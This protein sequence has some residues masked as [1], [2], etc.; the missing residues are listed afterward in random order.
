[1]ATVIE[2]LTESITT[3]VL[4][5]AA[6]EAALTEDAIAPKAT[7][8]RDGETI[9]RNEW[10]QS[11]LTA[12]TTLRKEIEEIQKLVNQLEPYR[13]RTKMVM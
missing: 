13:V 3:K 10:R 1:M 8:T 6:Y 2:T 7:Y 9:Y 12:I 11:L 5:I 4:L